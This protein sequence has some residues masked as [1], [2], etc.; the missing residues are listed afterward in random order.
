MPGTKSLQ[1]KLGAFCD[2]LAKPPA[3]PQGLKPTPIS[4]GVCGTTGSRALSSLIVLRVAEAPL[5]ATCAGVLFSE[6]MASRPKSNRGS[7]V[8]SLLK[9]DNSFSG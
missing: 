3:F 2:V 8:A 7:F 6:F 5:Y 9:D 4:C 1:P